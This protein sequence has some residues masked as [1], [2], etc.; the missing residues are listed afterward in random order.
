MPDSKAVSRGGVVHVTIPAA[1]ASDLKVMQKITAN[2]LGKLGCLGCHSGFDIRYIQEEL[3]FK[4]D[5]K[6]EIAQ[7]L[8]R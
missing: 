4:A 7:G 5:L 2:V 3:Y 6:G 8:G 1:A